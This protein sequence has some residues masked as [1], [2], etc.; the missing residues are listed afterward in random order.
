LRG[1]YDWLEWTTRK[2]ISATSRHTAAYSV[3]AKGQTFLN[4][5]G[6][7]GTVTGIPIAKAHAQRE[8]LTAHAETQEYLLE[9]IT[10]IFAV[11]IGRTR[12]DKPFA[13]AGFLLIGS[14]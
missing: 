5:Y 10:P 2:R 14:I 3:K 8:A 11:P 1:R 7:L 4:C 9:I 12:R 6:G 13:R